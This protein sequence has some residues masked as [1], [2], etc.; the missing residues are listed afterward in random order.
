[1]AKACRGPSTLP[2]AVLTVTF[3]RVERTSS[4]VMPMAASR[5]GSTWTRTARFCSPPMETC[6]TPEICEI[7]WLR[8]LSA[9][10]STSI[11]GSVSDCTARIRIGLSAGL[12]LR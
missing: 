4:S 6:D 5:A 2:L 12:T 10:S 7:C 11:S 9:Q 3:V 1:M 8:M